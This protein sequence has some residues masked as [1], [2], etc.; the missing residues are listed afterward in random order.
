[1]SPEQGTSFFHK[2]FSFLC[3]Q[4]IIQNDLVTVARRVYLNDGF[5][6]REEWTEKTDQKKEANKEQFWNFLAQQIYHMLSEP[7]SSGNK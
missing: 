2:S 1:M 3:V 7:S 5:F 6:L 4:Q